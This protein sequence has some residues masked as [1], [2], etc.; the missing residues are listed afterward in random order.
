MSMHMCMYVGI[1]LYIY[2]YACVCMYMYVCIHYA[3]FCLSTILLIGLFNQCLDI[4]LIFLQMLILYKI[5]YLY[6]LS[7]IFINLSY[8]IIL[9]LYISFSN[10]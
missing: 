5:R 1:C 10:Y 8:S 2:I 7:V 3:F 6:T 9:V 4:Y